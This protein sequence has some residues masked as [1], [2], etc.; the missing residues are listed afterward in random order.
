[1]IISFLEPKNDIQ[2]DK[3][4]FINAQYRDISSEEIKKIRNIMLCNNSDVIIIIK[5]YNKTYLDFI[6]SVI[7]I[8]KIKKYVVIESENEHEKNSLQYIVKN[9]S[10]VVIEI[11]S[12]EEFDWFVNERNSNA[13]FCVAYDVFI[14]RIEE[15]KQYKSVILKIKDISQCSPQ[16]IADMTK[17]INLCGIE[18][19]WSNIRGARMRHLYSIKEYINIFNK[20]QTLVK[21]I[22]KSKSEYSIFR[23]AYYLIGRYIQ[24]DFDDDGEP[25][26]SIGAHS[27]RGG[28]LK[29][30]A[31]CEGFSEILCQMLNMLNIENKCV[32]GRDRYSNNGAM[33]VWNQ[34]KINGNWYNCDITSDSVNIQEN[35]QV[36]LCL[37]SD[38]EFFLYKSI[39]EN[40]EKCNK[41]WKNMDVERT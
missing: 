12:E 38:E 18:I 16:V 21:K 11:S 25:S 33:H 6:K 3:I 14:K 15:L 40:A 29:R 5:N 41:S 1:M 36:D 37:L 17:N 4:I 35:R 2:N 13:V 22:D 30:R 28:V 23:Q 34:V 39:S 27:L 10:N 20:L 31:V 24:Y 7:A 8:L 26:R 9:N 32:T 19:N